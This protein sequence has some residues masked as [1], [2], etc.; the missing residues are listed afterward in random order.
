MAGPGT[1]DSHS[2]HFHAVRFYESAAALSRIVAE[3]LGEGISQGCPALVV[4][5]PDHRAAIESELHTRGF[6]VPRLRA[7]GLLTI[8]DADDT[9]QRFMRDGMPDS[10]LFKRTLQPTL[11]EISG[12]GA[13]RAIRAYGEMVDV[14][15]RGGQSV[16]AVKLEILWNELA[17]THDFSLLCGYSMGHFYKSASVEEICQQHTH[18]VSASGAFGQIV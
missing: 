10:L 14:L 5:T 18:V 12:A 6:D 2:G 1:A 16:A 9:L 15:W 17:R 8:A 3:F 4:A 11:E 13:G 7:I